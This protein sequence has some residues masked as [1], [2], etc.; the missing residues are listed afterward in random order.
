[1]KNTYKNT[2]RRSLGIELQF[3]KSSVT[4]HMPVSSLVLLQGLSRSW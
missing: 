2:G 4:V 3:L 1:M